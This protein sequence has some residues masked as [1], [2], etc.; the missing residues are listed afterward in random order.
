MLDHIVL[1]RG[2]FVSDFFP[3]SNTAVD[4]GTMLI[5]IATV[6]CSYRPH[7]VE[8]NHFTMPRQCVQEY[9]CRRSEGDRNGH[10]FNLQSA[11]CI[12]RCYF[13]WNIYFHIT[14]IFENNDI[15]FRIYP[16][17]IKIMSHNTNKWIAYSRKHPHLLF[18]PRVSLL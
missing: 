5:Q 18:Y 13:Y 11:C 17:K 14:C 15:E 16:K 2:D 9:S 1:H 10:Y 7:Y 8:N 12:T 3:I 4:I 6:W